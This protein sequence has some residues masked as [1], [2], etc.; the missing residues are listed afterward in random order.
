MHI[1]RGIE[2]CALHPFQRLWSWRPLARTPTGKT[3][4]R[5]GIAE[6]PR[7]QGKEVAVVTRPDQRPAAWPDTLERLNGDEL[8]VLALLEPDRRTPDDRYGLA[9]LGPEETLRAMALGGLPT[10]TSAQQP[11]PIHPESLA[12]FGLVQEG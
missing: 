6:Q 5:S 7:D 1:L 2:D 3:G 11:A 8:A 4:P 9:G 12:A 10:G